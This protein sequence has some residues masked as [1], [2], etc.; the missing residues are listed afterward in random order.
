M[1]LVYIFF[2]LELLLRLRLHP[3]TLRL[4]RLYRLYSSKSDEADCSPHPPQ[5]TVEPAGDGVPTF[6]GSH[7]CV[8]VARASGTVSPSDAL[9]IQ[10]H[11]IPL[12]V[13][14][15]TC[16]HL[17]LQQFGH[18]PRRQDG[19]SDQCVSCALVSD[20]RVYKCRQSHAG[21]AKQRKDRRPTST[22]APEWNHL[23][24]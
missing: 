9:A 24:Y 10:T 6:L 21:P 3:A 8:A 23:C 22:A 14:T 19:Q 12:A 7:Y 15:E 18:G 1:I 11:D 4:P 2:L 16:E 5:R 13:G 17:T 20:L